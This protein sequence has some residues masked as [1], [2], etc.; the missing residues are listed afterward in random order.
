MASRLL[1]VGQVS[2]GFFNSTIM[3]LKDGNYT[4]PY[5][6]GKTSNV[7]WI[8]LTGSNIGYILP[9]SQQYASIGV[10]VGMKTGNYNNIGPYNIT[11][12]ARMVTLYID[13]GIGPYTFDYNYIIVP[14]VT[15][16]SMPN[17]IQQYTEEQV[18]A[19]ISTNNVSHGTMWPSLKR[20]AFV[21]WENIT[22]T[23]SCKSPT[24]EINI[25]LSNAGA[26]QLTTS[27]PTRLNT[28][29]EATVDRVG[30]GQGCTTS[31][32]S[33]ATKTSMSVTLLV[34]FKYQ[35][36]SMNITCTKQSVDK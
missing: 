12:T 21:L 10:Q 16:E 17:L 23:F 25:E 27:H 15:L 31:S 18:F 19:C 32:K 7:Q 36:Q 29:L 22:T 9:L 24:F 28:T 2:I 35:G 1:T 14:N 6:Q 26:F 8:H 11:T 33:D 3:S 5:V 34:S 20:A 30:F 4:F 13:H